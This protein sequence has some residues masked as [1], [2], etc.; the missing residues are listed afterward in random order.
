M[1]KYFLAFCL[2]S[3]I[4]FAEQYNLN[5][6]QKLASGSNPLLKQKKY[7]QSIKEL[8][9]NN[10]N[11]A[12]Y[13]QFNIDGQFTYQSD[14]FKLPINLPPQFNIGIPDVPKEQYKINLNINQLIWDGGTNSSSKEKYSIENSINSQNVDISLFKVKEIIN[15]LYFNDLLID[16]NISV[17][18]SSVY[19]LDTNISQL[20]SLV[21][22]GVITKS[23]LSLIEI[24]LIKIK[25]KI[26]ELK[27]DKSTNRKV[28]SIWVGKEISDNDQLEFP[29]DFKNDN[30][31]INRPEHPMFEYRN[32]L[33]D[34]TGNLISSTLLPK[35]FA[36]VQGGFGSPNPLNFFQTGGDFYYIAGLKLIWN[37]FD[38]NNSSRKKEQLEINKEIVNTEKENFDLSLLSS[39]TKDRSDLR[40][41]ESLLNDDEIIIKKQQSVLN[42]KLSKLKNGSITS[43]EYL[44]EFN[45]LTQ[46]DINLEIHKL[47]ILQ[48]KVNILT[49]T[50]KDF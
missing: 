25:Q 34:A 39:L 40:K 8:E 50:G 5:E 48:T 47:Q 41:Y 4:L 15:Q 37:P 30:N 12:Y 22:N 3:S 33:N 19:L 44:V 49:K 26:L 35:I 36:F 18:N 21:N 29:D 43:T 16:M 7:I 31:L 13:P 23:N 9:L 42:E 27:T 2:F 46:Y 20:T 32:K 38:W 14:V 11:S 6:L 17:L 45:K 1:Y 24:E 28:L 10:F